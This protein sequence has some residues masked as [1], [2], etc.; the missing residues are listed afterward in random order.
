MPSSPGP[1]RCANET[2]RLPNS[3]ILAL[4]VT[5]FAQASPQRLDPI[6]PSRNGAE[7]EQANV[8]NSI[9]LLRARRERPGDR[10]LGALDA[11][12]CCGDASQN[13]TPNF[14]VA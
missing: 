10:R 5:K 9:A 3:D 14:N 8:P 2:A 12:G 13:V 11:T 7:D 1:T 4:D 6:G